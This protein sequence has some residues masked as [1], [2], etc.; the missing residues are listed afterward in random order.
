[1][2][3][4]AK[5]DFVINDTPYIEGDEVIVKDFAAVKKL[6]EKGFIVPL[7]YK[8]LTQIEREFKKDKKEENKNGTTL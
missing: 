1:M 3:L 5:K 2:K 8:E 7:T 4:I 6:N